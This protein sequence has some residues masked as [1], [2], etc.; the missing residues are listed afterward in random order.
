MPYDLSQ[1]PAEL[2]RPD[3]KIYDF[4]GGIFKVVYF[5]STAPSGLKTSREHH[6]S[7]DEKLDASISRSRR[8]V[9]ELALCNKWKYFCTFTI[10]K[11]NYDRKD[12][13]SW[14]KSFSQWLR[15]QRKKYRK[16]GLDLS[17][18]FVLIPEQHKD[19]SWHMHGLFS[20]ISP[21]L[22]SF[23]EMYSRGEN[24][25]YKLVQ[26]GYFNWPDY[27]AKY[28]FCSFGVIKNA[29]A[30]GFYITKYI[31][32][33][34]QDST[35]GVGLNLY[36]ASWR[37]NRAKLHGD[38]YGRNSYLDQFLCNHYD[39]CSTGMTA[40]KDGCDW[41]FALEYMDADLLEAF[42]A[43]DPEVAPEVDTYF[44]IV[45]QVLDGF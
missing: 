41:S 36:Y 33:S 25:P 39:F 28:G 1:P 7:Y 22:I 12:L 40:V 14:H 30:A 15:D 9:L 27:Q 17:F 18:D 8:V 11:S 26:G 21:L 16:K 23:Q 34:L 5:K 13:K 42:K 38:I 32:K 24:V 6:L 3:Y 19:G 4:T 37:L 31:S 10:A 29:V 45:Q 20:D 44:E 35:L 43:D 2:I